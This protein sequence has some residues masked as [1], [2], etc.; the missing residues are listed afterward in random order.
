VSIPAEVYLS[1]FQKFH[2]KLKHIARNLEYSACVFQSS[3]FRKHM[4]FPNYKLP[5]RH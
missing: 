3:P 2:D 5:S 4:Q 1:A